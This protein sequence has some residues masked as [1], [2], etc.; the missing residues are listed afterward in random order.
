VT[1]FRLKYVDRFA[2]RHGCVRY[3]FR[4]SRG[5]RI[6]LPGAPGSQEFAD[7]Y[8]AALTGT[9]PAR[10]RLRGDVGTF[11]RLAQEYFASAAYTDLAQ[12]SRDLYRYVIE[13]TLSAED[14]GH[15]PVRGM[16]REHVE[17]MMDRRTP[18]AANN[19]LQCF[20]RLVRFAM[21]RAS[22]GIKEDPTLGV[23][24]RKIGE[25]HTWTEDQITQY[26]ARWALGTMERLAFALLLYTG[27]RIGDVSRMRRA[28]IAGN[29]IGLTQHKT[30]T[31]LAIAIHPELRK[32]L[33]A[34]PTL[35]LI[36]VTGHRGAYTPD[37]ISRW[38]GES[39]E[40]AGLPKECVA[41]GLRKAAARRLAEAG[42]SEHEIMSVT[43][44][45]SL[46]EVER[47]TKEVAQ[48]QLASAAILKLR[49]QKPNEDSQT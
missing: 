23:K 35:N 39:I 45:K 7:A 32:A 4:R 29:T 14:I 41:H 2:D 25:H 36:L 30:G 5:V 38:M 15:R 11:D 48:R 37:T 1:R 10:A 12:T 20:R 17:R 27:Q 6:S 46:K 44:H 18:G 31:K 40:A 16:T 42:C 34:M 43:G 8:A 9:A 26:E 22:W 47:Y 13:S 49:V 21:A 3:Y 19:L 33:D 28:D 24:K